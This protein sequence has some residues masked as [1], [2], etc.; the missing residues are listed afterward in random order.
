MLTLQEMLDKMVEGL[1]QQGGPAVDSNDQ[2]QYISHDRKCAIG[3]LLPD[4]LCHEL[5]GSIVAIWASHREPQYQDASKKKAIE[6]LGLD[7]EPRRAFLDRAQKIHDA[8]HDGALAW[9]AY[10]RR[11]YGELAKDWHLL[12][13]LRNVPNL[14]SP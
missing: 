14:D 3:H 8:A 13:P 11:A 7:D 12:D 9:R 6:T 4:D 10:L 1:W 5:S 2:C